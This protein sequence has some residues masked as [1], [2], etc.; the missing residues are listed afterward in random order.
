M[1]KTKIR[2][3]ETVKEVEDL[4]N[5]VFIEHRYDIIKH[6]LNNVDIPDLDSLWEVENVLGFGADCGSCYIITKSDEQYKEWIRDNGKY[7]AYASHF[8]WPYN[9]Q[10]TTLKE[11]QLEWAIKYLLVQE[12]Y[13]IYTRLS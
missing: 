5:R 12:E 6:M 8:E 13:G 11:I 4:F 1:A 7:S 2:K 9:T 10:S 3:Y